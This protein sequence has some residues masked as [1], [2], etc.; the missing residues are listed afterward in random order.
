M[1]LARHKQRRKDTAC[2][3]GILK[4]EVNA[5]T[6]WRA[7]AA[8]ATA[9]AAFRLLLGYILLTSR[10]EPRVEAAAGDGAGEGAVDEDAADVDEAHR[11]PADSSLPRA[12]RV[13][14][15][16]SSVASTTLPLPLLPTPPRCWCSCSRLSKHFIFA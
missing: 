5:L 13:T 15:G 9:A 3:L 16:I 4:N 8:A 10:L 7:A 1:F 2:V 11:S 12:G 14:P 6:G